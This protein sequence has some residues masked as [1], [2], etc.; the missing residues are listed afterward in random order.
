MRVLLLHPARND[1]VDRLVRLPP[2]GLACVGG[3]LRTAG[4]EVRLIDAA[5]E[6]GWESRL[7]DVLS[8]WRPQAVGIS[9][10]TAVV[11]HAL[12]MAVRAKTADPKIVT[13]LG[14]VHATLFPGEMLRER[15]ID[16]AV[17]GEGEHTAV[18]LLAAVARAEPLGAI[19]GI[20]FR[21]GSAPRVN[22]K[23]PPISNL[24]DLPLPA[25]D[26]LPMGRYSTPFAA[27]GKV[28]SMVTS[29]GCPYLC[30]FCDAFVV[31]GRAY[32]AQSAERV[33]SEILYV[34]QNFGVRMVVFK[35]SEFT[36]DR[37]RVEALCDL[38][39]RNGPRVTWT[40]SS[41]VTN[42]D[43]PLLRKMAAAGCR[44]I[45][46]GVESADP[47]VLQALK[48]RISVDQ[49]RNAF[50]SARAAG[51]ETVAN[52]MVG[53]PRETWN[54]VEQTKRL[55]REIQPDYL[56]VQV[57]VPYPGTELYRTF[58]G[59]SPLDDEEARRRSRSLLR[60]FYLR[61]GAILPRVLTLNRTRWR[62]N[63]TAAA[64]LLGIGTR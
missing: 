24:D 56:N 59:R 37:P 62:Q 47:V 19:A 11:T 20:A 35:D 7:D 13:I 36:L 22:D 53:T 52:L 3:A 10:A 25:Y 9:A 8:A 31:H 61:P 57:L 34:V 55:I 18:E 54:S 39:T 48:K 40:C 26:L 28:C 29:R 17:H 46:F 51:I 32:R 15:V 14:G 44:V 64:Q 33:L 6:P 50:S 41:R 38:M 58:Q 49:V 45:Q 16:V 5:A 60:S 42:V 12:D 23:R 43:A 2:L 21:D 30:T 1:P 27:A 63:L 4:H